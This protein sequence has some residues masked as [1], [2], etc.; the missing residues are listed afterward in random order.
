MLS[1]CYIFFKHIPA[2]YRDSYTISQFPQDYT[3]TIFTKI[4]SG[5]TSYTQVC[6]HRE[7]D[8][9]FYTYV[10]KIVDGYLGFGFVLNNIVMSEIDPIFDTF[11]ALVEKWQNKGFLKMKENELFLNA[12]YEDLLNEHNV[13][14]V[15][16]SL[17]PLEKYHTRLPQKSFSKGVEER[18]FKI[19]D[20]VEMIIESTHQ[21]NY[22]FIQKSIKPNFILTA[23]EK[24]QNDEITKLQESIRQQEKIKRDLLSQKEMFEREIGHQRDMLRQE[25][26]R[27]QQ[28]RERRIREKEREERKLNEELARIEKEKKNEKGSGC[29][30][31]C[32]DFFVG[33]IFVSCLF[34]PPIGWVIGIIIVAVYYANRK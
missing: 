17:I 27:L 30:N 1:D 2:S 33:L 3:E 31:G 7:K 4:L 11:D 10:I 19:T 6:T 21:D 16:K 5:C 18:V 29:A 12:T 8:L 14:D 32:S 34:F 9:M 22:V 15:E 23:I 28:E 20:D 26:E 25:Q 13:K 24:A